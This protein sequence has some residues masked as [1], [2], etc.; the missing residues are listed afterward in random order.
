MLLD[1]SN[2][3]ETDPADADDEEGDNMSPTEVG[4]VSIESRARHATVA[5]SKTGPTLINSLVANTDTTR[6]LSCT[7][8]IET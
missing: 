3:N 5:V 2:V 8:T 7:L 4:S 6:L 1:V